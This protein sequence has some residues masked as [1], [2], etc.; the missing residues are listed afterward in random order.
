[1][2]AAISGSMAE[3]AYL[4]RSNMGTSRIARL[5]RACRQRA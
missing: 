4:D 2:A 5:W 1:M 3:R